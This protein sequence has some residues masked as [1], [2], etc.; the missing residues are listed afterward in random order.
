MASSFLLLSALVA[1]ILCASGAAAGKL[2]LGES[3]QQSKA[4]RPVAATGS[5]QRFTP[6]YTGALAAID[7]FLGTTTVPRARGAHGPAPNSA[8]SYPS[9]HIRHAVTDP[10]THSRIKQFLL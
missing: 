5:W 10:L 2:Y 8:D 4:A 3:T 9:E 6:G 7:L 1:L